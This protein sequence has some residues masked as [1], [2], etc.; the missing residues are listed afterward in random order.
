LAS[1]TELT[2]H[3]AAFLAQLLVNAGCWLDGAE[4]RATDTSAAEP[5]WVET[6]TTNAALCPRG[7]LACARWTLTQSSGAAVVAPEAGLVD[8]G[9]VDAGLVDAGLA[10]VLALEL[11]GAVA[12]GLV[13][14]KALSEAETVADAEDDPEGDP[15]GDPEDDGAVDEEGEPDPD[16]ELDPDGDP[17]GE[18]DTDADPDTDTVGE[19]CGVLVTGLADAE[20]AAEALAE[21]DGDA[22]GEGEAVGVGVGDGV[23]D[24]VLEDGSS[25]HVVS[26]FADVLGLCVAE[27]AISEPARAML[28]QIASTPR[29]SRPPASKLSVIARTCAKRIYICPA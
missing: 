9:L 23:G 24:G 7:M 15:E 25:W 20:V 19:G 21:G 13:T 8:A 6:V 2:V 1:D 4:V 26:V 29:I 22:D 10:L 16:G 27:T 18:P 3:V 28:G 17:D 5:F 11:A 14:M 12:W